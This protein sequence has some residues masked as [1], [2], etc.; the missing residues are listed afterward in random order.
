VATILAS[1]SEH[2]HNR[3]N[4]AV[5]LPNSYTLVLEDTMTIAAVTKRTPRA[6]LREAM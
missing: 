1:K 5:G 2:I 3:V 6:M 4:T